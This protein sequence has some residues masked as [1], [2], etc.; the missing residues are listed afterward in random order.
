MNQKQQKCESTVVSGAF[1][2]I[3]VD[4]RWLIV[5]GTL[6]ENMPE[7]TSVDTCSSEASIDNSGPDYWMTRTM[8][9][10]NLHDSHR[11]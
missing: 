1:K 10:D 4:G 2:A 3:K 9:I 6:N 8:L 11:W 5:S 7:Y